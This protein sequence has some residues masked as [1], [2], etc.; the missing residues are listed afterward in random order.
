MDNLTDVSQNR[1]TPISGWFR[2]ENPIRLDALGVPL[3][4]ETPLIV[5]NEGL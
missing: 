3:F 1:G 2:R 5:T 4:L